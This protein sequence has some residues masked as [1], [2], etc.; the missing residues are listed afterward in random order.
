MGKSHG[1]YKVLSGRGKGGRGANG[2][3]GKARQGMVHW[4]GE[5]VNKVYT[6]ILLLSILSL[7][8][9]FW[10]PHNFFSLAPAHASDPAFFSHV[11]HVL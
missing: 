7:P 5:S 10:M 4:D 2:W 6:T 11:L 9:H 3:Q 8:I 1:L